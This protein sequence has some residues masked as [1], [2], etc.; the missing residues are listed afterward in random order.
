MPQAPHNARTSLPLRFPLRLAAA[1]A[2]LL[3]AGRWWLDC[4]RRALQISKR[5][6]SRCG[7]GRAKL[8]LPSIFEVHPLLYRCLAHV[9]YVLLLSVTVFCV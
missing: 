3:A 4:L 7:A 1:H 8:L 2:A 9:E 5:E 6:A